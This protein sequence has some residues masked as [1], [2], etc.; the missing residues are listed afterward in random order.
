MGVVRVIV[1][2]RIAFLSS[3]TSLAAESLVT[4]N[5]GER[6]SCEGHLEEATAAPA[7]DPLR[8]PTPAYPSDMP[9][10]RRRA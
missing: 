10:C 3:R 8:E 1:V 9:E 7:R 5:R 4:C 6:K 2:L